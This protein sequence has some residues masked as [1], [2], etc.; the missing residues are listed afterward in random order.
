LVFTV[1]IGYVNLYPITIQV[2]NCTGEMLLKIKSSH[3]KDSYASKVRDSYHKHP[4]EFKKASIDL[5][6]ITVMS[7]KDHIVL[8]NAMAPGKP[9]AT[10]RLQQSYLNLSLLNQLLAKNPLITSTMNSLIMTA[11]AMAVV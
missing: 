4:T 7:L 10:K 2:C 8:F 1:G 9:A 5:K 6:S 3:C 11:N